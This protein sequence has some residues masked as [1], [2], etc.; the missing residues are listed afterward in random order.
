MEN[1]N[2]DTQSSGNESS[3]TESSAA[4]T[5]P[6]TRSIQII[7]ICDCSDSM[8]RSGIAKLNH[9]IQES[10]PHVREFAE[11]NPGVAI[12]LR[13]LKFTG[14]AE[15]INNEPQPAREY[16]WTELTTAPRS[17]FGKALRTITSEFKTENF[18][19][20]ADSNARLIFVLIS[21]G[22]PTDE[23]QESMNEFLASPVCKTAIRLVVPVKDDTNIPMDEMVFSRF[24]GE[25]QDREERMI[26]IEDS[27]FLL[28]FFE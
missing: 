12:Y 25:V 14:A 24:I 23:W 27:M 20:S 13:G 17:D 22:Y 11:N 2:Q 10:L 15:W 26:D 5:P 7:W 8:K 21:D 3:Q 9:I 1:K 19:P 28:K 18:I 6:S 4:V 16:E